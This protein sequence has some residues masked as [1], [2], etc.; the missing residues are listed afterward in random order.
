MSTTVTRH[1]PFEARP[2]A[3]TAWL[4]RVLRALPIAKTGASAAPQSSSSVASASASAADAPSSTETGHGGQGGAGSPAGTP[5]YV[6][7]G[8][9]KSFPGGVQALHG[10]DLDI[11]EG[12]IFGIIGRSGAGKS[13][14]LRVLNLLERPTQG[15]VQFDGRDL[16]ALEPAEL[17]NVRRRIGMIFQH[18]NLLSSR[19]VAE[20]VALPLELAGLPK[21]RIAARVTELLELVG[22]A[23]QRDRYPAQISGGQK[24]RVGIA[25]ALA[26]EPR[27]LLCDEA[28]SALD[29][30]TTQ[31]ILELLAD[32]NRRLGLTIVLITHQMQVIKAVAHRV[33]VLEHGKLVEQGHVA[34]IFTEPKHEIT[35]TMLREV[36]GSDIPPGVRE[37]AERLLAGGQ[38][39]IWRLTFRGEAVDRPALTVAGERFGIVFNILHG[40]IDEIQGLPFGALVV[41]AVAAQ[42]APEALREAQAYLATQE[43]HVEEVAL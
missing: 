19:T 18:F 14:L 2:A 29:P 23:A 25:R 40:Y 13:T 27:V 20:N 24:Q 12:E 37:R 36:I 9:E 5:L 15:S 11:R 41:T 28:T 33:L 26:N 35:R 17:R 21:E 10:I 43:F 31:S 34:D 1:L 4:T 32:I 22:L 8:I 38:G 39:H 7:R 42:G 30:E 16:L 6:L 3:R